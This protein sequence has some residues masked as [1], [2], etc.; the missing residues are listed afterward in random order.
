VCEQVHGKHA[1]RLGRPSRPPSR[2]M[3]PSLTITCVPSCAVSV[4]TSHIVLS[5]AM[6]V[7][8]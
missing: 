2:P 3:P 7:V 6:V 1:G 8:T 5:A 4:T